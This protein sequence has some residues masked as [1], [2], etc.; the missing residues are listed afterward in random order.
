MAL[1]IAS[2][3]NSNIRELEG[4]LIRVIA[5]ASIAGR[6][7]S[8][9]LARE[10]LRDLIVTESPAATTESIQKLVADYYNLQGQPAQVEDQQPSDLV[11]R[12]RSR[13]ISAS[14]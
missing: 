13:C 2:H 12:D 6:E 10:T 14:S 5:F 1:F 3:C 11:S 4:A 8:E 7:I 9:D